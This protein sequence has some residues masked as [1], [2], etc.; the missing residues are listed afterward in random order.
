MLALAGTGWDPGP[1]RAGC[2]SSPETQISGSRSEK[3]WPRTNNILETVAPVEKLLLFPFDNLKPRLWTPAI[4][5]ITLP[6]SVRSVAIALPSPCHR[7]A[8]APGCT[9]RSTYRLRL[10]RHASAS[11]QPLTQPAIHYHNTKRPPTLGHNTV[12][13]IILASFN[14]FLAILA[15]QTA[16]ALPIRRLRA[17]HSASDI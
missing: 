11:S 10:T 8:I 7:P 5:R 15:D 14:T 1:C 2:R 4:L 16:A 17:A 3:R 12:K 6:A 9:H 13:N